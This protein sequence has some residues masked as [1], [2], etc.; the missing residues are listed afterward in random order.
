M[1]PPIHNAK[2]RVYSTHQ[3]CMWTHRRQRNADATIGHNSPIKRR[4][5]T[6]LSS[7][8]NRCFSHVRRSNPHAISHWHVDPANYFAIVDN[9]QF[10]DGT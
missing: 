1:K 4:R 7:N 8:Q 10:V 9:C 2:H 3:Q 5:N 6:S